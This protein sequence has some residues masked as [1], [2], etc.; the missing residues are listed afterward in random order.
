MLSEPTCDPRTPLGAGRAPG[1]RVAQYGLI[2][3]R[4]TQTAPLQ[5]VTQSSPTQG[6][7][8]RR[9]TTSTS[10]NTLNHAGMI[11]TLSVGG[12]LDHPPKLAPPLEPRSG[13]W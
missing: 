9:I 10:V 5:A 4:A 13:C 7:C 8:P 3:R 6:T 12:A 1:D 11:P 2:E